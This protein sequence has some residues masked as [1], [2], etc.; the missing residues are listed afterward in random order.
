MSPAVFVVVLVGLLAAAGCVFF[1]RLWA[2]IPAGREPGPFGRADGFVA[3]ALAG[4][5]VWLAFQSFGREAVVTPSA[6]L[7][8]GIV[9]AGILGM[10]VALLMVRGISLDAVFG[11]WWRG[12]REKAGFVFLAFL[13]VLPVVAAA[14]WIGGHLDSGGGGVQPLVEYWLGGPGRG[15]RVLVVAMAVVVAPLA[16]EFVFRGYLYRVAARWTGRRMGMVFA[17]L[18]F[19]VIHA[20]VPALGGLFVLAMALNLVY[21]HTGSIWAPVL[22]HSAFNGTTLAASLIWPGLA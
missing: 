10:I 21:E 7:G 15:G 1:R 13:A 2:A 3:A 18:L 17:S 6:I 22:M 16:E 5:F 4:W 11:L 8:S 19:A 14:Q 9:Y 20:H 12:W